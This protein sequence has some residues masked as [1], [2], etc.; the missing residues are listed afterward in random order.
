MT[1]DTE[2]KG[3]LAVRRQVFVEEQG[4]SEVAELDGDE[5]QTLYMVVK[6]RQRVI[7]TARIRLLAGRQAKLERMAVLKPFRG[8]GI[9]KTI[10]SF[11]DDELK[12]MDVQ[13]IALH[14]QYTVRGFYTSCGFEAKGLPFSEA[15]M[16]HIRMEKEL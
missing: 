12:K 9:G 7:G 10:V 13:R 2:M 5:P 14:A 16:K 6:D 11:L 15:G 4:I 8:A 3:V 1:N